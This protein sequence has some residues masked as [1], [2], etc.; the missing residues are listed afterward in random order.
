MSFCVEMIDHVEVLV[1]DL[2]ASV[3]WYSKVLGLREICRWTPE[4]IMIGAGGTALALFQASANAPDANQRSADLRWVR[5]AWRTSEAGFLDAQAHL[6]SLGI[7]FSGP[8]DHGSTRSIYF[9][10]PDGHPLE[11][12]YPV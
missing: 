2:E 6:K 1:G 7:A 8:V 12:T 11:I 3:R 9:G 5:V 10:D 4:P